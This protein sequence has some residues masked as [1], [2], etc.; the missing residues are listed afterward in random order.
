MGIGGK[1]NGILI[2]DKEKDITSRDVVNSI[3]KKLHTK[4]V[5]HTGTL[6][7]IAT[8]VLVIC[9]GS[10]TKLVDELTCNDKEYIASVELG[11]NTDTLDNTGKILNEEK[12]IKNKEEIIKVL[13]SF[14]GK[15]LQEVPIYSAVKI[16][17]KKLYEYARENKNVELPKREVEIKDIELIDDI[18]YINDKTVFKFKC[19]VSKGTYIRSLIR[20][21]A[22]RLNTVGIMTDLRRTRQGK[23]KIEDAIKIEDINEKSL[24]NIIDVLDYKKI[25]L[26]DNIKKQVLNGAIIDNTYN[27][28]EVL[29]VNKNEAIA[30]YKE[31]EKDN[32]KLKPYKMFKGGE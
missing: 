24:I 3:V 6:D 20:D 21:I 30:L 5:G 2:I 13:N 7:P 15:Y 10:A 17:G 32:T 14:K 31:Y 28:N 27:S 25:E 9:V 1:M 22:K 8:G 26:T 23:F 29:F 18:E 19:S 4:K 16:N 12:S 11:T